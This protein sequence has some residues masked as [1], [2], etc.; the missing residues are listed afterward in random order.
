M[1]TRRFTENELLELQRM[2]SRAEGQPGPLFR[3]DGELT[4]LEEYAAVMVVAG[5]HLVAELRQLVVDDWI[6]AAARE[7]AKDPSCWDSRSPDASRIADVIRKHV[8]G[9]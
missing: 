7:I 3:G 6:E 9:T 5:P 8:R 4:P 2:A 1:V